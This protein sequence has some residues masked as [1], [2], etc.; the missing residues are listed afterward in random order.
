MPASQLIGR[1]HVDDT[2][3]WLRQITDFYRASAN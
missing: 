1:D 3:Y 2:H